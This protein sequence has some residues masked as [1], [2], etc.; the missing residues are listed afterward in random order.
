MVAAYDDVFTYH[1]EELARFKALL[2]E[3]FKND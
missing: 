2:I 3:K 1:E